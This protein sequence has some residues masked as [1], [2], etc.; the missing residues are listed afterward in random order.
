[1]LIFCSDFNDYCIFVAVPD[2]IVTG[3]DVSAVVGSPVVLTCNVSDNPSGTTITYQWKT[4]GI[5]VMSKSNSSKYQVSKSVTL[6]DS[7]VY[8]C[9]VTVSDSGNSPHVISGRSSEDIQL[10]VTSKC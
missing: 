9:E 1:M 8:T 4:G 7:D 10:S 6:S 2:P 5:S 3:S